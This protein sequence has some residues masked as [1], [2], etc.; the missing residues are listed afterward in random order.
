M[1]YQEWLV[2][3]FTNANPVDGVSV[4][5]SSIYDA[6]SL[7]WKA[8]NQ[9]TVDVYDRW[10]SQKGAGYPQDLTVIFPSPVLV[11]SFQLQDSY[12]LA[13]GPRSYALQVQKEDK[14]WDTVYTVENELNSSVAWGW[15]PVHQLSPVAYVW[16]TGVRLQILSSHFLQRVEL[17]NVKL[18]GY[19]NKQEDELEEFGLQE[20]KPHLWMWEISVDKIAPDADVLAGVMPASTDISTNLL[21]AAP[22]LFRFQEN[23]MKGDF[24]FFKLDTLKQQIACWHNR[25]KHLGTKLFDF[26]GEDIV[27]V[28]CDIGATG[29]FIVWEEP[30]PDPGEDT[31]V[32]YLNQFTWNLGGSRFRAFEGLSHEWE[33]MMVDGYRPYVWNSET[34]TWIRPYVYNPHKKTINYIK[35]N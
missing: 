11:T 32:R 2:P 3:K 26:E 35:R 8:F 13:Y 23:L 31:G 7:A 16:C 18:S 20:Q 12:V 15:R 30:D 25:F 4:S 21:P 22:G 19:G 29:E 9:T 6:T 17:A 10:V 14:N 5:A 33:Q 34:D 27:P 1:A 28:M 24:I